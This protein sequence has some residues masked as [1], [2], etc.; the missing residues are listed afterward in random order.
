[1]TRKTNADVIAQFAQNPDVP[2][3]NG[4]GNVKVRGGTLY[5]FYTAVATWTRDADTGEPVLVVDAQ[6]DGYSK[7]TSKHM[8]YL[9]R[10]L[11]GDE[12]QYG[13]GEYHHEEGFDHAKLR[14]PYRVRI[15]GDS[16]LKPRWAELQQ[17]GGGS[18]STGGAERKQEETA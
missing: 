7:T 18:A 12:T 6:W 16:G 11:V 13:Y 9:Y 14:T 1:M 3:L 10:E 8:G 5:S 17:D 15:Q 4:Y 2:D